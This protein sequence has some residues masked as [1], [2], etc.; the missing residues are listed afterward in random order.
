MSIR[1][2]GVDIKVQQE[3]ARQ[4]GIG[5]GGEKRRLF[6]KMR[7]TGSPPAV[8]E[9]GRL[10]QMPPEGVAHGRENL[11]GKIGLSLRF[12]A[13]KKRSRQHRGRNTLSMAAETVHLPSP[14]SETRP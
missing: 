1:S 4:G 3:G 12:E 7:G 2:S 14:E 8:Q 5:M 11:V 13:G 10:F 6:K 9:S